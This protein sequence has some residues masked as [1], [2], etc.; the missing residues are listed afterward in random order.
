MA[1]SFASDPEFEKIT[2]ALSSGARAVSI[3]DSSISGPCDLAVNE[4]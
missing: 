3:S 1:V 4:W 2:R